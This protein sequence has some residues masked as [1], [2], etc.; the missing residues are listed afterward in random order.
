MCNCEPKKILITSTDLMM[1]HFLVPHVKNLSKNRFEVSIACSIVGDKLPEV[2]KELGKGIKI[3]TVRLVRK[4]F[5]RYNLQGYLDLKEI[6]AKNKFV[7][8]WTNEPVMGVVT[9]AA[10]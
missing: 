7:I 10:A 8:I 2:Q 5:S 1:H 9:R 4:P 6:V 3:Y